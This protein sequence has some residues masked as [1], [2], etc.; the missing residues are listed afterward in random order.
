MPNSDLRLIIFPP[1]QKKFGT[2][3]CWFLLLLFVTIFTNQL[4]IERKRG[5]KQGVLIPKQISL[6]KKAQRSTATALSLYPTAIL[7]KKN[8]FFVSCRVNLH[9]SIQSVTFPHLKSAGH[10]NGAATAFDLLGVQKMLPRVLEQI[11]LDARKR[12]YNAFGRKTLPSA[13]RTAHVESF[14]K[15]VLHFFREQIN[16]TP[17]RQTSLL[18]MLQA[19]QTKAQRLSV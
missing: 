13:H 5:A 16:R 14:P 12:K 15:T 9:N 1:A 11:Q 3:L 18:R 8:N 10:K 17:N 6:I 2:D 7:A 4:T 19:L